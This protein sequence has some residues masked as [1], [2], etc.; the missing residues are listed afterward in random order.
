MKKIKHWKYILFPCCTTAAICSVVIPAACIAAGPKFYM[1]FEGTRW[2]HI[3]EGQTSLPYTFYLNK[4]INLA[5]QYIEIKLKLVHFIDDNCHPKLEGGVEYPTNKKFT[6]TISLLRND[7]KDLEK[8]DLTSFNI[9]VK[10]R[11][12]SNNKVIW[13][14]SI[15]NLQLK[16][17]SENRS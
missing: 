5:K 3:E 6:Q 14:D 9:Y 2:A 8:G 1:E 17:G 10:L 12:K 13:S 4:P 16:Y 11:S 7:G 15:L